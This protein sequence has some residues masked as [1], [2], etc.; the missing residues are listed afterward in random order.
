MKKISINF[1]YN[2]V[3][4]LTK[5][6]FNNCENIRYFENKNNSIDVIA[7]NID[8]TLSNDIW[9]LFN[10]IENNYK[11]FNGNLFIH[12]CKV[13]ETNLYYIITSDA[14]LIP[15]LIDE[16]K[17]HRLDIQNFGDYF[18]IQ[19]YADNIVDFAFDFC[20]RVLLPC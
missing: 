16:I 11:D 1:N 10:N 4:D 18:I 2:I 14:N 12:E 6:V 15:K 3:N 20:E 19:I 5:I 8:S 7:E 17:Y 13:I 9:D